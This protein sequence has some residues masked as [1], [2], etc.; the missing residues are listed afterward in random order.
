M[1]VEF[2]NFFMFIN[3]FFK[4]F[5]ILQFKL[6][7]LNFYPNPLE[8]KPYKLSSYMDPKQLK[9]LKINKTCFP[10]FKKEFLN[11]AKHINIDDENNYYIMEYTENYLEDNFSSHF[12]V[13]LQTKQVDL[14]QVEVLCVGLSTRPCVVYMNLYSFMQKDFVLVGILY[15]QFS[16]I[17]SYQQAYST[18]VIKTIMSQSTYDEGVYEGER[19]Y[20]GGRGLCEVRNN[21]E[22]YGLNEFIDYSKFIDHGVYMEYPL[23]NYTL[24]KWLQ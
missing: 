3:F 17:S 8:I 4:I 21:I 24:D 14:D 2:N 11:N 16:F 19:T 23:V 5:T 18:V 1:C 7:N 22:H 20:I 6:N 10:K 9:M 15:K 13:V 12:N